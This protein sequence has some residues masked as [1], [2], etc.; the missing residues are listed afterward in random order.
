MTELSF[1][2]YQ[3]GWS[4][5]PEEPHMIKGKLENTHLR[6]KSLLQW[7]RLGLLGEQICLKLLS[8]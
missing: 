4:S 3:T 1:R 6:R 7:Y 5:G 2:E 8:S